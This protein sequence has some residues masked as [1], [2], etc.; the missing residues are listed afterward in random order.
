MR[1][2]CN[3]AFHDARK[4]DRGAIEIAERLN[5]AVDGS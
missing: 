5:D 2:V 1:R 3:A 4:T